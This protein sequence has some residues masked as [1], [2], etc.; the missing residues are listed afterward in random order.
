MPTT[1]L[2]IGY[3]PRGVWSAATANYTYMDTVTAVTGGVTVLYEVISPA[4]PGTVPAGTAVTNTTYYRVMAAG[5]AG[6]AGATGATGPAG[7]AG[8]TGATGA[9]GPAGIGFLSTPTFAAGVLTLVT[10]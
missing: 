6:P 3:N 5:V 10:G 1:N 4:Y 7:A 8:A 2:K 9:T